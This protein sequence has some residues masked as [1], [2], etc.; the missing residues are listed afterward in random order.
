MASEHSLSKREIIL[1]CALVLSEVTFAVVL[2]ALHIRG[3]RPFEVFLVSKPGLA[4]LCASAAF[5]L[6]GAVVFYQTFD[7]LRSPSRSFRLVVMMN[8]ITVMLLLLT[9][10]ILVRA[11]VT[12]KLQF[13]TVG[14]LVLT[15]KSWEATKA[16][17]RAL[18]DRAQGYVAFLVPDELLGWRVGPNRV[19]SDGLYWSSAEGIRAPGAIVSFQK[20]SR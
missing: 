14:G 2:L 6:G 19:G 16:R 17:Y 3:E 5:V 9:S 20:T 13:E 4:L 11:G 8:L 12:Y 10:E 15:P 1:F 7:H 18:L